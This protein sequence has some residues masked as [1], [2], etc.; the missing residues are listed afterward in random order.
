LV[1]EVADITSD[2]YDSQTV[3]C[4][5]SEDDIAEFQDSVDKMGGDSD[6]LVGFPARH[7]EKLGDYA[8]CLASEDHAEFIVEAIRGKLTLNQE[9][10]EA[11]DE[12]VRIVSPWKQHRRIKTVIQFYLG[13]EHEKY[14]PLLLQRCPQV[15]YYRVHFNGETDAQ[16]KLL[17]GMKGRGLDGV[18]LFHSYEQMKNA[19]LAD[20]IIENFLQAQAAT[21]VA[22]LA[23]HGKTWLLIEMA[24]ALLTGEP[25]CGYFKVLKPAT[26]V[27][28]LVPEITMGAAF[29]RFCTQFKLDEYLKSGKLLIATLST[30]KKITLDD[31]ELLDRCQDADIILDTLPRFRQ[32]GANESDAEGNQQLAEQIFTLQ[33][34]GARS[35][36]AAQHSPKKFETET[37]MTLENVVRGS[38]DIGAMVATAWG[39]RRV[40]AADDQK[41]CL[42]YVQNVKPRDFLPPEPFL[43]R[44]RPDIDE[45][46]KIGMEKEPGKCG[47]IEEEKNVVSGPDKKAWAKAEWEKNPK[48]GR[49]RLNKL[50]KDKF[51]KGV[52]SSVCEAWLRE[53]KGQMELGEE[54]ENSF[55]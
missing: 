17:N 8:V 48:I 39:L 4:L 40:T 13:D 12:N 50:V 26:R 25:F 7:S 6:R 38:G 23:S 35:V 37:H 5:G 14:L 22:A 32:I 43:L 46:G 55:E 19:P 27:I 44:L 53:W 42:V 28:Y 45:H 52:D 41:R 36:I 15:K 34:A 31:P 49:G 18:P 47:S 30:G 16:G 33:A 20:F 10:S 2:P 9:E 3:L 1:D 21:L 54:H 24:R 11:K 29:K 51:S